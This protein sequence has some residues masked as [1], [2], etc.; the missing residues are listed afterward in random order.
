[1]YCS[2]LPSSSGSRLR[3]A[4]S[5]WVVC[6]SRPNSCPR[7]RITALRPEVAKSTAARISRTRGRKAWLRTDSGWSSPI[8]SEPLSPYRYTVDSWM[9]LR[10]PAC[11]AASATATEASRCNRSSSRQASGRSPAIPTGTC[12]RVLITTS[13]PRKVRVRSVRENTSATM[14]RPPRPSTIGIP[15]SR[16]VIPVTSWPAATSASTASWPSTPVAPVTAI[17][18]LTSCSGRAEPFRVDDAG[19]TESRRSHHTC[20]IGRPGQAVTASPPAPHATCTLACSLAHRTRNRV[21]QRSG[22]R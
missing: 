14:A 18:T 13:W 7:R 22:A 4:F 2:G 17:L 11:A 16:R 12:A 19:R 6:R 5:P 20:W 15:E 9:S 1:M 3:T 10:A 8:Q 21:G